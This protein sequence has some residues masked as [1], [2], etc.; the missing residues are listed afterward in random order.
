MESST[1]LVLN[2]IIAGL[3]LGGFYAALSVGISISFGMLDVV[4]IAHP[5]FIILGSYIAY[6]VN[7]RMGIDPI[8]VSVVVSPLFFA[9]GLLLYRIYYLCFEKRGQESL[10]GLAFFFGILFITEVALVLIFGVDYRLVQT[11]YSETTWRLGPVDF[12]MRLVVPFLVS[13]T[14]VIGVQ[15]FLTHT[16]FGRAVLA[17]AQDQLALRLMGVNPTRVKGLAFALSIA[18]AGVAGAF[19]I[20][21]QPVQPAIGR[22]FIGLVFAVCVLGG[23]GS[24]WGTLLGA[25]VLGLAESFTSTFFGPSWAPAVSFGLLL[26]A[27][28]F[29]PSGLLGR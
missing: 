6:I 26:A 20:V 19:L 21:I 14:M 7:D 10:R 29:K 4:N 25:F 13:M 9:L 22:E 17:V 18:T 5:G 1:A 15:L 3:L 12:P 24:I 16:F 27:L 28:A 2:A 23:M 8:L 11:A